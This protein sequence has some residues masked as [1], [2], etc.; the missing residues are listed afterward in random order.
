MD[1]ANLI[2][3]ITP[4]DPDIDDSE[5]YMAPFCLEYPELELEAVLTASYFLT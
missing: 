2:P 4:E 1:F 5:L 3:P